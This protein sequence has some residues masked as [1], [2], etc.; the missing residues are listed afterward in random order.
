M[1]FQIKDDLFDFIGEKKIIGKPIGFDVK[2]NMITLPIIH[3]LSKLGQIEGRKMLK[4]IKNNSVSPK[5]ILHRYGSIDYTLKI[6][7]RI[8]N[9]AEQ[10][11]NIFPDSNDKRL[12]LECLNFNL[13]RTN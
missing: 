7:D 9:E 12:L 5:E 2:K 3:L 10:E 6:L 8:S 1:A 11:L 4:K 13:K